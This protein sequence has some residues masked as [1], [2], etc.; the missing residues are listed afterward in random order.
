MESGH[1]QKMFIKS[2]NNMAMNGYY[3]FHKVTLF[4]YIIFLYIIFYY[5]FI[6]SS[7]TRTERMQKSNIFHTG[8]ILQLTWRCHTAQGGWILVP[9]FSQR[10]TLLP[11]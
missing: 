4:Y 10:Y 11:V 1:A 8:F 5:Y 9:V 7:L 3:H 6:I 2:C